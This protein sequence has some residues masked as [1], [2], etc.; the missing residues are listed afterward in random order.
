VGDAAE[1]QL[2][3]STP[4]GRSGFDFIMGFFMRAKDALRFEE[5]YSRAFKLADD[6]IVSFNESQWV[7]IGTYIETELQARFAR[8][9]VLLARINAALTVAEIEAVVWTLEDPE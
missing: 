5:S 8:G 6:R 3:S 2:V 7:A 4:G 9:E 1:F